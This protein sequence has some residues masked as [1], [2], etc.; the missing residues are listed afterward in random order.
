MRNALEDVVRSVYAALRRQHPSFCACAK[1]QDD[2]MALALNHTR[3]RYVTDDPPL[4]AAITGVVLGS[5][6]SRA[7]LTV[8][9]Y[10]AM[11]RVAANPRHAH[12]R[13][14]GGGT[15]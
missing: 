4:G 2:V 11:R 1:C 14:P 5:E 3:P 12:G 6:Q 10:D 13:S 9:I 8:V 15:Y 7:E